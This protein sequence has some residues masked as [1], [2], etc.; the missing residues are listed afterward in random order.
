MS[1]LHSTKR[2][3]LQAAGAQAGSGAAAFSPSDIASLVAQYDLDTIGTLYQD[4]T[5]TTPVASVNDPIGGVTATVGAVHLAQATVGNKPKWD[6][7]GSLAHDANRF[8]TATAN[9]FGTS[10]WSFVLR[11]NLLTL[12]DTNYQFLAAT[13]VALGC[14]IFADGSVRFYFYNGSDYKF[15][16]P[17]PAGTVTTGDV[18]LSYVIDRDASGKAFKNGV[19]V[20]TDSTNLDTADYTMTTLN[21]P[22]PAGVSL[23][24]R[25]KKI[26][27][28]N[29]ALAAEELATLYTN[30]Y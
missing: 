13:G 15:D 14:N 2:A 16:V 19:L 27:V 21:F 4:D 12:S 11:A 28:Y 24:S 8:L 25:Y 29:R 1:L 6:G 26:L 20:Q 22:G 9:W 30:G 10:D 17:C 18:Q 23:N 7:S 5:R 3:L